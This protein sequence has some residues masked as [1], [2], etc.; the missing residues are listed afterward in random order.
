[1]YAEINAVMNMLKISGKVFYTLGLEKK[2]GL[3]LILDF[4]FKSF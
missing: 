2:E 4:N 3:I 1:M